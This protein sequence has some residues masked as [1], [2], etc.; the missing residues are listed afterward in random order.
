[1]E[2][3]DGVT[4]V[5]TGAA[6]GIGAAV[7]R[8]VL[9]AGGHVIALDRAPVRGAVDYIPVDL[10][11]VASITSAVEALP[12]P[13]HALCSVAGVPGTAAPADIAR[14]NYLGL[15]ELTRQLLPLLRDGG[16]VVNIASV[17]GDGWRQ[18][19][20]AHRE[21]AHTA[22]FAEGLAWISG[23]S[24]VE[25]YSYFK[26]ALIVWSCMTAARLRSERGIT[27]N[28]VS[29]GIVETPLLPAFMK[30]FGENRMQA[31]I[32]AAGRAGQPD[33]I[34]AVVRFLL[35][36]SSRWIV[37]ENIRVDGGVSAW[38]FAAG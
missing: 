30:T 14:I 6:S 24:I 4:V 26:E 18:R 16:A 22:S 21:L 25:P 2:Q 8:R 20:L 38:K 28:C 37:G 13:I 31:A 10:A 34:A 9:E 12:A 7:V 15:R 17:A 36:P 27:M 29:P 11:D 1:M 33:D 3:L 5:V 35:C 19:E 23:Q 32:D